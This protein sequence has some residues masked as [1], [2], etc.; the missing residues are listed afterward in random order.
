[1]ED[2]L[3]R[4]AEMGAWGLIMPLEYDIL[5]LDDPRA[6]SSA[7]YF[8][9][10]AP[11]FAVKSN[12]IPCSVFREFASFVAE[13]CEVS[14]YITSHG[15]RIMKNSLYFPSLTGK[16]PETGSPETAPTAKCLPPHDLNAIGFT[17]P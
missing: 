6:P 4:S 2:H 8:P 1:M 5:V 16:S 15:L 7:G 14:D 12:K 10:T 13:T 9:D 3:H 11:K 17:C